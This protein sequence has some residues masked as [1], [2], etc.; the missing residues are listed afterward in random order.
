M[1]PKQDRQ[2]V[3]KAS[4]IEQKYKLNMDTAEIEKLANNAMRAA[5]NAQSLA[6]S[7]VGTA[8]NAMAQ[9]SVLAASIEDIL[10]R[11]ETLE[12]GGLPEGYTLLKYIKSSGT[13][14]I[15]TE[16]C[17]DFSQ[18]VEVEISFETSTANVRYSVINSFYK[19]GVESW[20]LE[21]FNDNRLRLYWNMAEVSVFV[22]SISAGTKH[23]ARF[24]WDATTQT[25]RLYL[26]GELLAT[27][28]YAY[29]GTTPYTA[30]VF[31]DNRSNSG[32]TFNSPLSVYDL[33]M[34][35]G[36]VEKDFV[37]CI[38]P[39]VEYGMYDKVNA[40]FYGN[41]GSGAFTGA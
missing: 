35:N 21:V 8:N 11:L 18:D 3:R 19:S 37:A 26:D 1:I 31:L 15:D 32:A 5:S 24:E 7:A 38:N 33:Y 25:Y 39:D 40:K 30:R 14:S 9:I 13:Q 12:G 28:T 27:N 22:G 41:A 34:K 4:D 20:G 2:G 17:L 36:T 29:S 6:S 10:K 16:V 23:T